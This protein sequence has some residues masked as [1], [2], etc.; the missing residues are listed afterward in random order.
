MS[1]ERLIP[2][3]RPPP[4]GVEALRRRLERHR[5]VRRR[6]RAGGVIAGLAVAAGLVAAVLGAS[7][8]PAR[9]DNALAE[10]LAELAAP[11]P[12]DGI[13]GQG[14]VLQER[15]GQTGGVRYVW[16]ASVS[17]PGTGE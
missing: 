2:S 14:V 7:M 5:Q 17:S 9:S 11:V 8:Q 4:G 10:E 1:D 6:L 13:V 16:F 12:R 15:P 3:L